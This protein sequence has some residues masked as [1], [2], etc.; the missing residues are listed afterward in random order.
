MQTVWVEIKMIS[1]IVVDG[2]V[3][4]EIGLFQIP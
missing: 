2:A 1:R 4:R 3:R